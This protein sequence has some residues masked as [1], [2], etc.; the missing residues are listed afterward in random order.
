[1]PVVDDL[2]QVEDHFVDAQLV[3]FAYFILEGFT[4]DFLVEIFCYLLD[5]AQVTSDYEL[6]R[7]VDF[8]YKGGSTEFVPLEMLGF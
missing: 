1:M 2:I 6:W 4:E 3:Y 5:F 8:A 7:F